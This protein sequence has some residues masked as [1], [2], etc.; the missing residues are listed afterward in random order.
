MTKTLLIAVAFALAGLTMA[1]AGSSSK[2]I[3]ID[4]DGGGRFSGHAGSDWTPDDLKR[5]VAQQICG[6]PLPRRFDL[7]TMSG[8][9]LFSGSC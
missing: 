6:G 4:N 5:M 2:K 7:R 3:S 9:W 1:Q 8:F